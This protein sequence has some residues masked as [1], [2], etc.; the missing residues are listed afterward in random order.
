VWVLDQR[1][2]KSDPATPDDAAKTLLGERQ[3]RWLLEGL[4]TSTAP[5]K[6]ICSPCTVFMPANRRD[7]NWAAGFTAE[8]DALLAHIDAAVSGHVVFL[9]GDTHLTGV[10]DADGHF[11][12]RACPLGIPVPND[13]TL[14]NP[15]AGDQLRRSAG[16]AYADE[17]CHYTLLDVH[18]TG[19][20]ATLEVRVVREDGTTPYRRTFTAPIPPPDLRVAIGPARRRALLRTGRLR[21]RVF[22]DRPGRVRLRAR[23]RNGPRL[24]RRAI[25]IRR[26]GTRRVTL[27]IRRR[28]LAVL[29]RPGRVRLTVRARYRSTISRATRRLRGH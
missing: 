6:V 16:V 29:R 7:G 2:F 14:S 9:T 27:R 5:F 28:R 25:R 19:D 11:E 20:T 10:Y 17:R 23:L 3:R 13:V 1:R 22:L 4:A 21:V 26:P 18:G 15:L 8:R 12:V 24:A